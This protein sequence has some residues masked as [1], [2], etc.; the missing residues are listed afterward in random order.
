MSVIYV[1]YTASQFFY[2]PS[3][4]IFSVTISVLVCCRTLNAMTFL[5][6]PEILRLCS[7]Q[8]LFNTCWRS[9]SVL[10]ISANLQQTKYPEYSDLF[11]SIF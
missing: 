10:G 2:L 4:F 8:I 11:G 3:Y 5:F 6:V 9:Y 1:G 7:L